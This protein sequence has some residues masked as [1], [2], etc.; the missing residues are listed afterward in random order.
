MA[1]A[2]LVPRFPA[3]GAPV[4]VLVDFDGTISVED[5]TDDLLSRFSDDPALAEMDRLYAEG[6]IGSRELQSWDLAVLPR[7]PELLRR[8]AARH[9]VDEGLVEL[10]AVVRAQAAAIEVVSDGLGFYVEPTLAAMGLAD[11][12]V[13]T[14]ESDL[15]GPQ[16]MVRFPYG[17]PRCFV[18]GTC[19]RERV[20]AHQAAR[21][22]V[23]FI[24]DGVS[25]RFAAAHAD[26][27]FAK[28][29]LE[30]ICRSEG[31]RYEHWERLSQVAAWIESA[32]AEGRLP[33]SEPEFETWHARH[34]PAPRPFICGPEVWGEGRTVPGPGPR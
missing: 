22:A 23:V 10:V 34:A 24:G 5:V 3:R 20:R 13:A 8:E 12:P 19:K 29:D 25:D 14:N 27:V 15:D 33:R 32:F 6:R 9:G 16:P 18:C 28:G 17:H 1:R 21:R 4:S 7:D 2:Q 31:W 26:L 11:L 30:R